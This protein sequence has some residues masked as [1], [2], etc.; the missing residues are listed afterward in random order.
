[1]YQDDGNVAGACACTSFEVCYFE[2]VS[3]DFALGDAG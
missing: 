2:S 1:M 3:S